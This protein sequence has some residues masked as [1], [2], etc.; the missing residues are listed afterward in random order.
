MRLKSILGVLLPLAVLGAVVYAVSCHTW[1]VL[2]GLGVHPYPESS[3]TPWTYQ[4]WSGVIPALTVLTLFGALS[5]VYHLHNCHYE[6][7]WRLGRH[8]VN[9]SPWCDKHFKD[10]KPELTPEDVLEMI[11]G[12]LTEIRDRH[13]TQ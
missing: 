6:T 8:R 7:C 2:Y 4:M 1:G 3:S 5:S 13:E 9:G 10:V 12:V 11:L